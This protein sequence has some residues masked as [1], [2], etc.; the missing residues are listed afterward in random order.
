MGN[1]EI[2]FEK[3]VLPE[4]YLEVFGGNIVKNL[5][6]LIENIK[7][8]TN[9]TFSHYVSISHNA[10]A[11]WISEGYG[12]ENMSNKIKNLKNKEKIVKILK[13]ELIKEE[14][15]VKKAKEEKIQRIS[16]PKSKRELIK[17]LNSDI[18]PLD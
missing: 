17:E 11:D 2:F 12:N 5:S 15:I 9:E 14:K 6:E 13:K 1:K 4:D 16:P 10:F 3:T 7:N 8:M 18:T